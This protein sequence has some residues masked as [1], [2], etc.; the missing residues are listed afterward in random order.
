MNKR[1]ILPFI[2]MMMTNIINAQP[3]T[4]TIKMSWGTRINTGPIVD[5]AFNETYTS[6][7]KNANDILGRKITWKKDLQGNW[8]FINETYAP[9]GTVDTRMEGKLELRNGKWVVTD[10]T[11]KGFNK[12]EVPY[13]LAT[14]VLEADGK[15]KATYSIEGV[16][17]EYY[18]VDEEL[19]FMNTLMIPPFQ[20]NQGDKKVSSVPK[21]DALDFAFCKVKSSCNKKFIFNLGPGYLNRDFGDDRKGCFGVMFAA[22]YNVTTNI[23]TGINISTYTKSIGDNNLNT[24]FYLAEGRYTFGQG[25]SNCSQPISIFSRIAIGM[26]H[27]KLADKSGSAVVYGAGV[28]GNFRISDHLKGG[29]YTDFLFGQIKEENQKNLRAG[30]FLAYEFQKAK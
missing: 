24:S 1:Y 23:S 29:A 3:K 12:G 22:L 21:N 11:G 19:N 4:E 27:E 25:A 2:L 6:E 13:C 18:L 30:L 16:K 20:A 26:M 8:T 9:S 17:N 7:F 28:G 14:G 5:Q 10:Y 15:F